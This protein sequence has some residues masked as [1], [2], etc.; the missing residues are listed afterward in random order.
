MRKSQLVGL[1][2]TLCFGPFGLLYSS[3]PAA[4]CLILIGLAVGLVT[5]GIGSV[6]IIPIAM[7]VSLFTVASWNSKIEKL[8]RRMR[9]IESA[10]APPAPALPA[11]PTKSLK[12]QADPENADPPPIGSLEEQAEA[13]RKDLRR[14]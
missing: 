2:L 6:I 13:M 11:P 9:K 7:F 10:A 8:E 3:V 14:K 12:E 1:L 4:G 5:F